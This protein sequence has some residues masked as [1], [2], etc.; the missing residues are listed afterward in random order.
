MWDI[1]ALCFSD[2]EITNS[3]LNSASEFWLGKVPFLGHVIST[4]GI[5]VDN[6]KVWD[7]LDRKPP[8]SVH[9]VCIFLRLVGY[10]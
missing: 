7:V 2:C 9:Q 4:E 6:G 8:K 3:M 10:Y 5:S 1:V